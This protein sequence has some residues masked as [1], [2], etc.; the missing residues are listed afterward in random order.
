MLV[1]TPDE[2]VQKGLRLGGF[3]SRQQQKVN[4]RHISG[5]EEYGD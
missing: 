3:D 4:G 1:A 5:K 2:I